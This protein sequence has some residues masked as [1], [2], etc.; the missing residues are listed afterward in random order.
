ML[1]SLPQTCVAQKC[2][3]TLPYFLKSQI[4]S[5]H[6]P[7]WNPPTDVLCPPNKMEASKSCWSLVPASFWASTLHTPCVTLSSAPHIV[8]HVSFVL[9]QCSA[10]SFPSSHSPPTPT[11]TLERTYSSFKAYFNCHLLQEAFLDIH[12]PFL[13]KLTTL[14]GAPIKLLHSTYI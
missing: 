14:L 9:S 11:L 7:T 10:I 8:L 13:S 3:S 2:L 12:S 5:C 6:I 1:G 4:W